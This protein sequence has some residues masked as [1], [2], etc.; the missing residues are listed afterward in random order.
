MAEEIAFENS[1]ISNFEGLV[2]RDLDLDLGLGHTALH[3]I[4]RPLPTCQISLKS[5]KCFV[6]GQ[7][8]ICTYV[9]PSKKSFF[10]MHVKCALCNCGLAACPPAHCKPCPWQNKFAHRRIIRYRYCKDVNTC[11]PFILQI[12]RAKVNSANVDT[13]STLTAA[14]I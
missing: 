13:I 11:M 8:D 5:K 6:D 10:D 14:F 3:T 9:C 12:S 2:S 7:A 4:H 1:W